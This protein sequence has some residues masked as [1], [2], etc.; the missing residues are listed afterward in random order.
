MPRRRC[1]AT[2]PW[3]RCGRHGRRP[4]ARPAPADAEN[5]ARVD[6]ATNQALA[7]LLVLQ[8][9]QQ[10]DH[11]RQ[12]VAQGQQADTPEALLAVVQQI[13]TLARLLQAEPLEA[14]G[15]QLGKV[16]TRPP[17]EADAAVFRAVWQATIALPAPLRSKPLF[18]IARQVGVL[19]ETERLAAME[20]A[21]A[22]M[23]DFRSSTG[24]HVAMKQWIVRLDK[25]LPRK[26]RSEGLRRL[27]DEAR[28][29]SPP[30]RRGF[31]Q[32]LEQFE[33]TLNLSSKDRQEFKSARLALLAD[34]RRPAVFVSKPPIEAS[35]SA[36]RPAGSPPPP[37]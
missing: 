2:G 12:L 7:E 37:P 8:R 6:T 25:I 31:A 1:S 17:G 27:L 36:P 28:Q 4:P 21:L 23:Q 22:Q 33:W 18:A 9:S 13:P 29:L 15:R 32:F 3:S 19:P 26:H 10:R 16:T 11:H 24:H 5:Y 14:A 35:T 20:D 34:P 30:A